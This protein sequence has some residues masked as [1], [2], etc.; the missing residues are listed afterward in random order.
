VSIKGSNAL[1]LNFGDEARAE[2]FLNTRLS[3]GFWGTTI[4]SFQVPSSYVNALRESAVPESLARQF[5]GSPFSVDVNQAADQFGLRAASFEELL[6]NIL[7]GSGYA[8]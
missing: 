4:K 1:F 5:P 3:Q 8:P 7:P 2:E 6:N